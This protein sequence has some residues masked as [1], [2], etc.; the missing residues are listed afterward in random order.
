MSTSKT[1]NKIQSRTKLSNLAVVSLSAEAHAAA[2]RKRTQVR[3]QLEDLRIAA[4]A[5]S[6]PYQQRN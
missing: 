4:Q 2:Q 3:R 1:G 6:D 5:S